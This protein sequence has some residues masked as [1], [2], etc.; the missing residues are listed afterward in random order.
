MF[1][2]DIS[3]SIKIVGGHIHIFKIAYSVEKNLKV[4]YKMLTNLIMD[5][6]TVA[7]PY[8]IFQNSRVVK[9]PKNYLSRGFSSRFWLKNGIH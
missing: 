7:P 8:H 1:R 3:G 5:N 9:L 2:F 6:E 4:G